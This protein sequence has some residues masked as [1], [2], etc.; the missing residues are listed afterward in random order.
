MFGI[1]AKNGKRIFASKIVISPLEKFT[2]SSK[3]VLVKGS[4]IARQ[5]AGRERVNAWG[6]ENV[7]AEALP[8]IPAMGDFAEKKPFCKMA[9]LEKK[10]CEKEPM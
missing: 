4:F 6:L 1:K 7:S 8:P 3:S 10:G 5:D 2:W 9:L